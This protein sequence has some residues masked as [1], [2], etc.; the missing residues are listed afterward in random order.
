[1]GVMSII[2]LHVTSCT[3]YTVSIKESSALACTI[4]EPLSQMNSL[5]TVY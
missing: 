4:L 2:N 5:L 3:I 1:M